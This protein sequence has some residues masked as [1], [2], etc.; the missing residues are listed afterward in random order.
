MFRI[1]NPDREV[2]LGTG[3]GDHPGR[4]EFEE[5]AALVKLPQ[6]RSHGPGRENEGAVAAV[7]EPLF[8]VAHGPPHLVAVR[9]V[10]QVVFGLILDNDSLTVGN[11]EIS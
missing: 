1:P 6:L 4:H 8:D 7:L 3:G 5:A 11:N 9:H 2:A 10:L